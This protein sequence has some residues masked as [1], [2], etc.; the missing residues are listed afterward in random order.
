MASVRLT[1]RVTPFVGAQVDEEAGVIRRACICGLSSLNGNDYQP[2][3]YGD[4]KLYEGAK[5]FTNHRDR[6]GRQV[7]ELLGWWENTSLRP[8]GKPE[9]DF[10]Y[11]KSHPMAAR[12]VEIAKRNP[13]AVGFSH[14]AQ[15]ETKPGK[16]GRTLV[17][18]VVKVESIDLVA[19]PATT[20]GFFESKGSPMKLDRKSVV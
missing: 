7:E 11:L 1:E 9:G 10:H 18:R 16:D 3:C 20:K 6:G 17:E 14:V 12:M 19:D 2:G 8:D 5:S 13:A 15:C 4:G